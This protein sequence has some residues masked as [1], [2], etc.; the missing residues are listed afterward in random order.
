MPMFPVNLNVRE[1][2]CV[3]IGGGPVGRR[4]AQKLHRH[5]ARARLV[6][7]EERPADDQAI[8]L[9]WVT[10]AYGPQHLEGAFLVCAAATWEV[11]RRVLA[12]A[13]A[14]GLLVNS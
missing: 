13:R 2:L 8:G 6:C 11:N 4:R 14:R 1:R 12:D 10:A 7:L 3:V 9:E 5:G